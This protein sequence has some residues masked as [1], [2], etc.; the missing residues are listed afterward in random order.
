MQSA[1]VTWAIGSGLQ[2]SSSKLTWSDWHWA[3]L[4]DCVLATVRVS[5][6]AELRL[7]SFMPSVKVSCDSLV[8][9]WLL[10]VL[11]Q[12]LVP[13]GSTTTDIVVAQMM[14]WKR[15][16]YTYACF[17]LRSPT[18]PEHAIQIANIHLL[19][20]QL[21][22]CMTSTSSSI[23][24]TTLELLLKVLTGTYLTRGLIWVSVHQN[25]TLAVYAMQ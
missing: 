6:Y 3:D 15:W 20:W 22:R 7:W 13:E 9:S 10:D 23:R 16:C 21:P 25:L 17:R 11:I 4:V 12:N 19:N 18:T 2:N 5:A 14:W 24:I 8:N 1:T